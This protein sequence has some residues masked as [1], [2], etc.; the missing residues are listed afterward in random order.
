M[1][2]FGHIAIKTEGPQSTDCKL[3]AHTFPNVVPHFLGSLIQ[4]MTYQRNCPWP[5][6]LKLHFTRTTLEPLGLPL[7]IC[8]TLITT[9]HIMY[10]LS[11][12]FHLLNYKNPTLRAEILFIAIAPASRYICWIYQWTNEQPVFRLGTG[13][14]GSAGPKYWLLFFILMHIFYDYKRTSKAT[15]D[16][17]VGSITV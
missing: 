12:L 9:Q 13:S 10:H 11:I 7:F 8:M 2:P 14:S 6:S 17:Q 16:G 15:T 1:P 3:F 4:I 5:F